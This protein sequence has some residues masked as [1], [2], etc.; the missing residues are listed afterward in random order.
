MPTGRSGTGSVEFG[1]LLF[2]GLNAPLD[3]AHRV[4]IL[5]DPR[6]V[7][8]PERPLQAGEIL[9]DAVEQAALLLHPVEPLF[10]ACRLRRTAARR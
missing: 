9:I 4:E 10:A 5:G 3:F 6:A 1:V 7:A 8:R 2:G